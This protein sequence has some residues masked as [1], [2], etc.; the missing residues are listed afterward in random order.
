MVLLPIDQNEVKNSVFREH[1]ECVDIL[2]VY[3]GFYERVGYNVPWIGYFVS[4][5]GSEIIGSGG[6]KGKPADGKVEIAYG[7]FKNYEGR[8]W[9]TRICRELVLLALKTDDSIR[10]TARTLKDGHA[11]IRILEKNGF[12]CLGPVID[13]EDGEVLE[14]EYK[15]HPDTR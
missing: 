3:P 9:G 2:A 12:E 5:D 4:I 6:Y 13:P 11:S 14:W 10:I 7:T 15:K 1:Q 8:G